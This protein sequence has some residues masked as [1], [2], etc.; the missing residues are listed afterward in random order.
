M[1]DHPGRGHSRRGACRATGGAT[2]KRNWQRANRRLGACV[3]GAAVATERPATG[4]A[5]GARPGGPRA[6]DAKGVPR[7]LRHERARGPKPCR[8]PG[9]VCG[10]EMVA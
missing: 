1:T 7:I 10:E 3:K 5:T 9:S 2:E 4:V 8:Q 6:N